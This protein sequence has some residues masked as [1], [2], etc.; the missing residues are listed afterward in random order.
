[1]SRERSSRTVVLALLGVVL[2][3][4][5]PVAGAVVPAASGGNAAADVAATPTPPGIES[6]ATGTSTAA[7][8]ATV[9]ADGPAEA[10]RIASQSSGKVDVVFVIDDTGSMGNNIDGV[11]N[12]IRGFIEDIENEGLDGRYALITFSRQPE[13]DQGFT[14][15]P[16]EME[17]ALGSVRVAGGIE[18]NFDAL[19]M[20]TEM[21]FRPDAKRVIVDITDEDADLGPTDLRMP[22]VLDLVEPF[23]A[24]VAVTEDRPGNCESPPTASC[25]DKRA[26]AGTLET[27]SYVDL[28]QVDQDDESDFGDILETVTG[29]ITDAVES[30][31]GPEDIAEA[32]IEYV[33]EE[34]NRT[35]AQPG[36]T[37]RVNVTVVNRGEASGG[38]VAS[39]RGDFQLFEIRSGRLDPGESVELSANISF[40][41]TGNHRVFVGQEFVDTVTTERSA[42]DV[43]ARQHLTVEYAYLTQLNVRA[44]ESYTAVARVTNTDDRRHRFVLPIS[45]YGGPDGASTPFELAGGESTLIRT[46][47]TVSGPVDSSRVTVV[48]AL[49]T[50][51][52]NLTVH[53]ADRAMTAGVSYAYVTADTA[54]RGNEYELVAVLRNP[55]DESRRVTLAV[56][57]PGIPDPGAAEVNLDTRTVGANSVRTVRIGV[58]IAR[59]PF[60]GRWMINGVPADYVSRDDGGGEGD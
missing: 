7:E 26:L 30:E 27:G 20:A 16:A 18:D 8:P 17:Q 22:E 19:K 60:G 59:G 2:V 34:V 28:K 43:A 12:N 58:P 45:R 47:R 57:P 15:D 4:T 35:T 14:D 6:A 42:P 37:I 55:A 44:G 51:A 29:V 56:L 48:R 21:E 33:D 38:Y 24:Y 53:P 40:E 23:T 9:R 31:T 32:D 39:F 5:V 36:G 50:P 52:G 25:K 46:Q 13:L 54:D 1:M 11:K 10:R 41:D 3:T 49:D